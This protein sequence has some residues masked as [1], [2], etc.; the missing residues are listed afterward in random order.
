MILLSQWYEPSDS[1][2]LSEL[3]AVRARNE[4]SG[5][6]EKT[7]YLDGTIVRRSFA[8]LLE[9]A[10]KDFSGQVC[11]IANADIVFDESLRFARKFCRENRIVTLTRWEPP[12][13][14][15]SMLGHGWGTRFFSGTQDTWVFVAGGVPE[16]T[17]PIP[18]GV[19]GCD[20]LLIGW[21]AS[22]GCEVFCPAMSI[23][24]MHV[25]SQRPPH[26]G[27]S[28]PGYFGYPE[29]VATCDGHGL[30]LVHDWP[31][32]ENEVAKVVSTCRQ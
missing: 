11:V 6:F 13:I 7:V 32:G 28:L 17:T 14:A 29:L 20:Q 26:D 2:R 31:L 3:K 22:N 16:L 15:P 18:M 8:E 24:T 30:V 27:M 10:A 25:H 19:T 5:V 9:L 4:S 1:N 23:R 21:A 12:Y